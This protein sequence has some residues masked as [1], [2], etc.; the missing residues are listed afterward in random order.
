MAIPRYLYPNPGDDVDEYVDR[1]TAWAE[2]TDVVIGSPGLEL[3]QNELGTAVVYKPRNAWD[4]PFR[5]SASSSRV[6][7][8]LGFLNDQIPRIN[9]VTVDGIDANE[10]PVDVPQLAIEPSESTAS[11]VCLAQLVDD[12]GEPVAPAD[13]PEALT[14]VHVTGELDPAFIQG[15]YPDDMGIGLQPLARL[16]WRDGNL[17]R[18]FQI[19]YHNL[20]H[21]FKQGTGDR[22]G[23]H[24]FFAQG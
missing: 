21:R 23:R 6:Q 24:F 7:V 14:I 8:A 10:K 12:D 11:W 20:G 18:V 2:S 4:H 17:A 22:P 5:V 3:I 16:S 9:G 13:N 1:L 15:G 19:V